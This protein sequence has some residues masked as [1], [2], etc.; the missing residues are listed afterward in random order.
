MRTNR[1]IAD[2]Q[3]RVQFAGLYLLNILK[4]PGIDA[5]ALIAEDEELLEPVLSWLVEKGYVTVDDDDTLRTTGQGADV[6]RQFEE[7]YQRFLRDYD[8]F[9]AVD[10]EAGDFALAHYDEYEDRESWESFLAQERWDDLR[11]AVAEHEG[12]DPLEVVF[13]SFLEDGRFGR[14][15]DEW[16]YDRLLGS[17]WDEI[18]EICNSALRVD[19]LGYDDGDETVSGV[20]VIE[21]VIRQGRATMRQMQH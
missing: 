7:R 19:D 6:V 4:D 17:V 13:M 10:L 14:G 2:D 1:I 20:A 18:A 16:D 3:A 11:I 9:C 12:V 5:S 15:V 21:D 8:V